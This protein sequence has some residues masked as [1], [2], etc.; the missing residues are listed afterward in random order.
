MIKKGESAMSSVNDNKDQPSVPASLFPPLN[1]R[2]GWM[3]HDGKIVPWNSVTLHVSEYGFHHGQIVWDGIRVYG[4]Q[5]HQV[6]EHIDRFYTAATTVIDRNE[7]DFP[8][9]KEALEEAVFETV[10]IQ[11][12]N[13]GYIRPVSWGGGGRLDIPNAVHTAIMAWE[14]PASFYK[15]EGIKLVT[16]K[17]RRY[18]PDT[19]HCF[20]K[21]P[22]MYTIAISEKQDAKTKGYDDILMLSWDGYVADTSSS[23]I[24]LAKDGILYTP[25]TDSFFSGLTRKDVIAC[26]QEQGIEVREKKI[27]PQELFD[28]AEVFVTGTLAGITPVREI[29]GK[30]KYGPVGPIT[31]QIQTAYTTLLKARL[32][33]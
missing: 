3:W 25:L 17:W 31:Q 13:N 9:S 7:V 18:H 15:A 16:S 32:G 19:Y 5:A 30:A 29:A 26:A 8:F 14:T 33:I 2:V 6:R 22:G 28:A 23:N 4:G 24:F 20:F 12:V 10:K 11:K 27:S 1:D 21:T